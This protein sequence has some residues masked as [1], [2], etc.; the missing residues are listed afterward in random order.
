MP[1]KIWTWMKVLREDLLILFFAWKNPATPRFV[2]ALI[3][4]AAG[5]LISPVDLIPDYLPLAG[6]ADDLAVVP[7]AAAAIVRLLPPGVRAESETK[8]KWAAEKAPLAFAAAGV[9]LVVWG[10]FLAWAAYMLIKTL[11]E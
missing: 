6:M 7:A 4:L 1:M 9:C 11:F 5:Y 3:L 8:A 2:R 10:A